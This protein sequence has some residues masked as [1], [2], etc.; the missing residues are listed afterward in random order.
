VTA[1]ARVGALL[2]Q[3]DPDAQQ[4]AEGRGAEQRDQRRRTAR[5]LGKVGRA[6][7]LA[8]VG[9]DTGQRRGGRVE[10]ADLGRDPVTRGLGRG[11]GVA[12]RR[13]RGDRRFCRG[14]VPVELAPLR[15]EAL[16]TARLDRVGRLLTVGEVGI[17]EGL[18]ALLG[19]LGRR[20]VVR[21]VEDQRPHRV[22]DGEVLEQRRGLGRVSV[23]TPRGR[24]RDDGRVEHLRLGPGPDVVDARLVERPGEDRPDYDRGLARV[25][26]ARPPQVPGGEQ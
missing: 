2:D 17:G 26:R 7:D 11:A 12:A 8:G 9:V 21:H 23:Q 10:V 18:R 4:R 16:E 14:E 20:R 13:G 24:L 3:G 1:H 22:V 15:G 6:D 5:R 19:R 25:R